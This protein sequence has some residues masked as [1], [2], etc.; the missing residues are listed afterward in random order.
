[1]LVS[2]ADGVRKPIVDRSRIMLRNCSISPD[3]R[4]V[5]WFNTIDNCFYSYEISSGIVRNISRNVPWPLFDDEKRSPNGRSL[6]DQAGWLEND[7][8]MLVYDRYDIWALDPRGIKHPRNITS[9]FGRSNGIVLAFPKFYSE[10]PLYWGGQVVLSAFD[11][12]TKNNGFFILDIGKPFKPDIKNLLPYSFCIPRTA[13]SVKGRGTMYED[14][15]AGDL[16]MAEGRDIFVVTRMSAEESPNLY[17]THDFKTY[18]VLT[19]I[20]PERKYNWIKAELMHWRTLD[21]QMSQGILYKPDNFNEKKKY[22]ILFYYYEEKSDGLHMYM[23]PRL[24]EAF[25]NIPYYVSNGYLVFVP[26]IY[27]NKSK[28]GEGVVSSVVS[29]AK[30]LS[31]FAWID[32]KK[33]GLQGQSFGGY[34]TNYLVTHSSLFAAACEGSGTSDIISSYGQVSGSVCGTVGQSRQALFELDQSYIGTVPWRRPDLYVKNS[35]IF[36]VDKVNTPLLIW[37]SKGDLAVPFE[38]AVEMFVDMRRAGKRVWLL[39]YDGDGHSTTGR[40]AVDLNIRMKQFF[41]F[42]LQD[43][44]APKWMTEGIPRKYKAVKSGLEFDSAEIKP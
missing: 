23:Q 27:F 14:I 13:P 7:E 9:G 18:R 16:L 15:S 30:Y 11:R 36:R 20:Y 42:Y 37:H 34:E 31:K 28:L 10:D 3:E 38:Q 4:F 35:P 24:S 6:F 8:A 12:R 5:T 1:M 43:A 32:S 39:Q 26:D 44:P 41:D 25:I 17:L 21:G 2:T 22:P 33:M 19:N 40:N 29:A